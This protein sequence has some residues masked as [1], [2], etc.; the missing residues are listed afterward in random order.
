ME[1]AVQALRRG[2]ADYL[3]KP[4]DFARVKMV[5]ANVSRTRELKEEIGGLRGE[6]RRARALRRA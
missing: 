3:T 1:T 4:V 5:L 6:L 2:V